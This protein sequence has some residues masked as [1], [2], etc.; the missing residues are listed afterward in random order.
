MSNHQNKIEKNEI[1]T[2][3]LEIELYKG[4][5]NI[6]EFPKRILY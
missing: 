4:K 6:S 2:T 5:I 1:Q 3:L